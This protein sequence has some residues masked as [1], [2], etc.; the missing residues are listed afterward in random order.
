MGRELRRGPIPQRTVWPGSYRTGDLATAIAV[1]R[2]GMSHI[3]GEEDSE[4]QIL[5]QG[6]KVLRAVCKASRAEASSCGERSGSRAEGSA[7]RGTTGWSWPFVF[8]M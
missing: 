7:P 4:D 5:C 1:R 3:P 2:G 6:A 8:S